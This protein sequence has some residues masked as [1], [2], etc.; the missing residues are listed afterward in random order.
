MVKRAMSVTLPATAINYEVHRQFSAERKDEAITV[1]LDLMVPRLWKE[2]IVDITTVTDQF[3]YDITSHG[4]HNDLLNEVFIVGDGD[5]EV[6]FA[7]FAWEMR[8]QGNTAV[9]LHLLQ[10]IAGSKTLRLRGITKPA[11]SD[12]NQPQLQILTS[13]AAIYLY[14]GLANTAVNDQVQRWERAITRESTRLAERLARHQL[15][16]PPGTV[17]TEVYDHSILDFNFRAT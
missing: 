6:D 3:D 9:N 13:R 12:I 2:L 5:T 17:R 11:L 10:R 4:F 15:T 16:A 14:E 1:A 7:L 8:N